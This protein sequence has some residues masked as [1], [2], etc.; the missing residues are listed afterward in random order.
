MLKS[1]NAYIVRKGERLSM[2]N[3]Q[4]NKALNNIDEDIIEKYV[5]YKDSLKPNKVFKGKWISIVA[6]VVCFLLIIP[7]LVISNGIK[8]GEAVKGIDIWKEPKLSASDI[9]DLFS[10][11]K[12][13]GTNMYREVTVSSSDDTWL[14]KVPSEEYLSIYKY[15]GK[16]LSVDKLS[17]FANKYLSDISKAISENVTLGE[18]WKSNDSSSLRIPL[19]SENYDGQFIQQFDYY[20]ISIHTSESLNLYG[21]KIYID[22]LWSDEEL[23]NY[24]KTIKDKLFNLFKQSFANIDIVRSYD[25]GQYKDDIIEIRFYDLDLSDYISMIFWY[26]DSEINNNQE[27]GNIN[28]STIGIYYYKSGDKNL[29]FNTLGKT[30]MLSI[31]EAEELLK[32][33]YVFG[34]HVCPICMSE[35]QEVDFENYDYVGFEYVMG[36]EF[37]DKTTKPTYY[38][39][40]YTFYKELRR[41]ENGDITYAKTYVPAFEIYGY[42]EYLAE[43]MELH[44]N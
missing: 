40:F 33:G 16:E 25:Q 13:V 26:E 22:Y 9:A 7:G 29:Y 32:K 1:K 35:Q 15:N 11:N 28:P 14:G 43:Q 38:V 30:K 31:E 44:K 5:M 18:I 21:E 34:N 39:P 6:A 12:S 17:G 36:K 37:I 8:K 41:S 4:I 2:N 20:G 19:N 42:E 23:L 27:K 24:A 10:R 3:K